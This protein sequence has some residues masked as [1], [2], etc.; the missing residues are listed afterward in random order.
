MLLGEQ[1]ASPSAATGEGGAALGAEQSTAA[2]LTPSQSVQQR[3]AG[4]P[5]PKGSASLA[6]RTGAIPASKQAS[7]KGGIP[8]PVRK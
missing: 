8:K 4:A 3:A 1:R 5:P 2:A 6:S 7:I